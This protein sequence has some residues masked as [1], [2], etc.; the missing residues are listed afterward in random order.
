MFFIKNHRF[1]L[2][3]FAGLLGAQVNHAATFNPNTVSALISAI[4][5]ANSN[6]ESDAN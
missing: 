1:A 6:G 2:I 3:A 5:T 4:N